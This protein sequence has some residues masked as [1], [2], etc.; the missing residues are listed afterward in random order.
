MCNHKYHTVAKNI[1]VTVDDKTG[2]LS[3]SNNGVRYE[4]VEFCSSRTCEKVFKLNNQK[5]PS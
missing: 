5:Y 1:T 4:S 3:S 2:S